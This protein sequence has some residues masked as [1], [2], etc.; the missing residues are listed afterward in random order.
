[1]AA[2]L[3]RLHAWMEFSTRWEPGSRRTMHA[4]RQE[5]LRLRFMPLLISSKCLKLRLHDAIEVLHNGPGSSRPILAARPGSQVTK[6]ASVNVYMSTT[7]PR[8]SGVFIVS[9][10]L[11]PTDLS[12]H[13]VTINRC[14]AARAARRRVHA[15]AHASVAPPHYFSTTRRTVRPLI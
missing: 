11:V 12:E 2:S 3:Q 8:K 6:L 14:S 13:S 15:Y 5:H 1:M 7:D 9:P 10:D 4:T